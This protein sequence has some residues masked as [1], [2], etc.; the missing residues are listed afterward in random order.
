MRVTPFL[1]LVS[2]S[3]LMV[4]TLLLGGCATSP[5][6]GAPQSASAS[7]ATADPDPLESMNR[8]VFAFNEAL[9][10][11]AL[12]PVATAWD[13]VVPEFVQ[14]GIDH[15]FAHLNMPIVLANDLLQRKPMAAI[16]D[17]ARI[18]HNTVFGLFG[19]IDVAT[20]VGIPDNDEDF[21]QTMGSYGVPAGPY[22]MVPILGPYTLRDGLGDIVDVTASGYLYGIFWQHGSVFPD[23]GLSTSQTGGVSIGQKGLELLNLRSIFDE[24]LEESRKD[25]F[26]YY[27][28]VRNAYLQNRRAKVADRTDAPVLDEADFYFFDD[29][30]E[31]EEDLEEENYDDF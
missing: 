1:R 18:T 29:E 23:N 9:D 20:M 13:F 7:T 6:R 17:V 22:L 3:L 27:I 30:D 31:G 19:F 16:E 11:Y 15:V 26:D 21:G 12:E 8:G 5:D 10:R 14:T 4:S 2:A 25:A 28:F 24:E